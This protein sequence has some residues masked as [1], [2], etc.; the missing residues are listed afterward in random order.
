MKPHN[1]LFIC[2]FCRTV[3]GLMNRC[4][5][6]LI[7]ELVLLVPALHLLRNPGTKSDTDSAVNEEI[8]AGLESISF[9]TFRERIR[10]FSDKR[11][12]V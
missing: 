6:N 8:W 9:T 11:R 2:I 3:I 10:G 4:A 1:N 7:S 12:F 5:K